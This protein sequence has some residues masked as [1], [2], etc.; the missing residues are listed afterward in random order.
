MEKLRAA[1]AMLRGSAAED[2]GAAAR[3][4]GKRSCD[5]SSPDANATDPRLI[6]SSEALAQGVKDSVASINRLTQAQLLS[7]QTNLELERYTVELQKYAPHFAGN[8]AALHQLRDAWPKLTH[9]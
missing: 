3:T 6:R 4:Q 9:S 8:P 2:Q 5:S 1:A 7:Q